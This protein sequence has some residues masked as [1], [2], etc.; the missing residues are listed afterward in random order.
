MPVSST[1]SSSPANRIAARW[2]A[3]N[4]PHCSRG[5]CYRIDAVTLANQGVVFD[6]ATIGGATSQI[7]RRTFGAP[8]S[9]AI[10]LKDPQP[11]L[12]PPAS[13]AF[14]YYVQRG[15]FKWDFNA[16]RPVPVSLRGGPSQDVAAVIGRQAPSHHGVAGAQSE[17]RLLVTARRLAPAP[18]FPG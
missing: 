2:V 15:W 8:R 7:V 6:R 18:W 9:A 10:T 4:L 5:H 16:A 17:G 1:K 14:Y 11:D 13:G 3:A 12:R